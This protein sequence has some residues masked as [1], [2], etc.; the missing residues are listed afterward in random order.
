MIASRRFNFLKNTILIINIFVYLRDI[1]KLKFLYNVYFENVL[2]VTL[3]RNYESLFNDV[4]KRDKLNN[5][6]KYIEI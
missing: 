4:L 6:L 2:S 3:N 5:E 1:S